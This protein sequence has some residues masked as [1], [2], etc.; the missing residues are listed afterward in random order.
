MTLPTAEALTDTQL[1]AI[2]SNVCTTD[3]RPDGVGRV[4]T[5]KQRS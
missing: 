4:P 1:P 5:P 2:A 3:A